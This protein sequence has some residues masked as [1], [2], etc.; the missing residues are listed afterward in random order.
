MYSHIP[1]GLC[2]GNLPVSPSLGRGSLLLVGPLFHFPQY[3]S[4]L[5]SSRIEHV[6]LCHSITRTGSWYG[7]SKGSLCLHPQLLANRTLSQSR[8]LHRD[9]L[10]QCVGNSSVSDWWLQPQ[11]RWCYSLAVFWKVR[12]RLSHYSG[13][14]HW[15]PP[16][17]RLSRSFKSHQCRFDHEILALHDT[18][19]TKPGLVW[20]SC[21]CLLHQWG[22]ISWD[23]NR[24]FP[25]ESWV[26]PVGRPIRHWSLQRSWLPPLWDQRSI[27]GM[28][29]LHDILF[30]F[31]DPRLLSTI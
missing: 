19:W 18:H 24:A 6:C 14:G 20:R 16:L 5:V 22:R 1:L 28:S 21:I 17:P 15:W 23:R 27:L 30:C 12:S 11:L 2:S 9:G 13:N 8:P 25:V 26:S 29:H 7:R 10:G 31:L 3:H 4:G